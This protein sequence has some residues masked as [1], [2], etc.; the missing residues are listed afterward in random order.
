[1]AK[2]LLG[3]LVPVGG[4]DPI[5]LMQ[6]VITIGRRESCD[7]CLKF[8]NV[9]GQHCELTFQDGYWM[10]RDLG[11]SNGIKVNGERTTRKPL[12]PGDQIGLATHKY[13]IQYNIDAGSKLDTALSEEEDLFGRSLM[14]KAGLQKSKPTN[15]DDDE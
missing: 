1:M 6:N 15:R 11:S 9:S 12:R 2:T 13:T 4:G 5:P 14:E 8:Q 3:E 7:I 10:I